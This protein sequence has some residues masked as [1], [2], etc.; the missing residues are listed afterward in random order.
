VLKPDGRWKRLS[1]P[2]RPWGGASLQ[3]V[4]EV[5][6]KIKVHGSFA[7]FFRQ[8]T[9]VGVVGGERSL[10]ATE[11]SEPRSWR[12]RSRAGLIIAIMGPVLFTPER[13]CYTVLI[14]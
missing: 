9:E 12:S 8:I 2:A 11:G 6:T 10:F 5:L 4:N 1:M 7:K 13:Q 14:L 3:V